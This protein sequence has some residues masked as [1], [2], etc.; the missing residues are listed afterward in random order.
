[1]V[2]EARGRGLLAGFLREINVYFLEHWGSR[3]V[4]RGME[5][6]TRVSQERAAEPEQYS[7]DLAPLARGAH[8][9]S[10]RVWFVDEGGVRTVHVGSVVVGQYDLGDKLGR[11]QALTLVARCK[12]ATQRELAAAFGLTA[13][14]VNRLCQTA[15]REGLGGL[16]RK[17]RR[18]KTPGAVAARLCALRE[19]GAR[20]SRIAE[21]TGVSAR[22]VRSI[23]VERGYDPH[24]PRGAQ[25]GELGVRADQAVLDQEGGP[26]EGESSEVVD[27]VVAGVETVSGA[28]GSRTS[29]AA[30]WEGGV[31]ELGVAFTEGRSVWG[32]GVLLAI[33]VE[34]G[35]LL[36]EARRVYGR[37]RGGLYGLRAL[38]Q[39]LYVM[40]WLG[41]RNAEGLKGQDPEGLGRLLGL[42]RLF[43]VKTLRRR[44]HEV[45]Q[46]QQAMA[47]QEAMVRRWV[48]E[49]EE[50][51]ATLY[52]DGHTRAYYGK[53][54]IA[55]GWCARRRLCQPATTEMWTNDRRGEPLL[56]VSPEAHPTVA[57]VLPQLLSDVRGL[58]GERRCL[59]A[60]DR[61]G[62]SGKTFKQVVAKGFDFVTYRPGRYAPLPAESFRECPVEEGPDGPRVYRLAEGR[63]RLRGYGESRLIAVLRDDAKQTHLVTSQETRSAVAVARELFGRWRQENY[64]KYMRAN[65]N[66]DALVDYGFEAVQDRE[67]PNPEWV[68][69]NRDLGRARAALGRLQRRAVEGDGE[70]TGA[71]RQRDQISAQRQT[72]EGFKARR[73]ALPK[74]A[75]LSET[76]RADEVKLSVE[77]KLFTDIVKLAAYRSECELVRRVAPSFARNADEGHTFVRTLLQQPADLVV[78]GPDLYVTFAPMSAP[79]FTRALRGLCDAVNSDHPTYPES[80]W[81]LHFA[82][83]DDD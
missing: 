49:V 7:L 71:P 20:V 82:V 58:I 15:A 13:R 57:Q 10:Q 3:V 9:V 62:W 63:L 18:D 52:V 53:R 25:Q 1:M 21:T 47:W 19:Q 68:A 78:R 45:G 4:G 72:V 32:A 66:L 50:E 5:Q 51:L 31:E 76:Q 74:R 60:F 59:V 22:T 83:R 33:A 41:V 48:S 42:E 61:G 6:T 11:N 26:S 34:G 69:I 54:K 39:G 30:T 35:A 28:E 67:I 65:Y 17:R 75:M 64:F 14:T 36:A 12:Y 44:L 81:Q 56:R 29:A 73:D 38:V 23:L 2:V 27:R 70:A 8:R 43:E 80:R 24:D 16:V 79:R 77:R 46:R 37:L 40:A 55:K